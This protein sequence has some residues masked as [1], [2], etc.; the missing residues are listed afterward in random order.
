MKN[1]LDHLEKEFKR[2]FKKNPEFFVRSPGR[3]NIIGE[4]SDY[5]DGYVMPAA[6]N[7]GINWAVAKNDLYK[8]RGYSLNTKE[9]DSFDIFQSKRVKTQ[10]LQYLQGVVEILKEDGE[11]VGGVDIVINGD[12]PIGGG[13]SSSSSLATGFAY[14]L[15]LLY[16]LGLSND[17][18]TDIGCKAEWWYGTKGGNMD[19]FAISHGKEDC[20]MFFDPRHFKY[21]YVPLPEELSLVIF[22]TTVRHNQKLSPFAQRRKQAEIGLEII[23]N[24]FSDKKINKLRDVSL[25]MLESLRNEMDDIIYRRCLHPISERQRVIET[26]EALKEKK[27]EV[28]RK[29]M[30]ESHRSLKENYEVT[31]PE[32]DIAFEEAYN[33]DGIIAARM[34]GGGFGGCTINLVKKEK[35]QDFAQK[36]KEVFQ[37]KTGLNPRFY[38]CRAGNGIQIV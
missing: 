13:L 20:V 9:G 16:N 36:L 33:I 15:S 14:I 12:L 19:H 10:W 25:E 17:D 6:I 23:K 22:E 32:I 28:L 37:K 26:K 18:L 35:S 3:V 30:I 27:F 29:N 21:E 7:L 38:I 2:I 8:V 24:K 31:C 4:H 11:R 34:T 1:S 5:H